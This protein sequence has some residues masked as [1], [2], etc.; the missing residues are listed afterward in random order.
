MSAGLVLDV[1]VPGEPVGAARPRAGKR[2]KKTIIYMPAEHV[3]A[4]LA[5]ATL[6]RVAWGG[7]A[8]EDGPI[9][10][11]VE[12]V[13]GRTQGQC[14]KKDPRE[15]IPCLKKPDFDNILKLYTDALVKAGVLVDDNIVCEGH[16]Y[17][18]H[19]AL[20][21]AEEPHTRVRVF[22]WSPR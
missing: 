14:R 7:C 20:E 17:T 16:V 10:V 3:A 2:G 11:E 1:I 22:R 19:V 6:F 21:P 5:A 15:R 8:A 9:I 12:A 13:I 18:E 4:E